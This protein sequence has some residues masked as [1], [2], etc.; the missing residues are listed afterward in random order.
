MEPELKALGQVAFRIA[1]AGND[2]W[3]DDVI[4]VDGIH[5]S[6]FE[7]VRNAL[8]RLRDGAPVGNLVIQGR[9]GIG[10]SH[11]LGRV[12][13][14]AVDRGQIF[15]LF[16]P[17]TARQFWDSLALAYG[18]ALH[19]EVDTDGTQLRTVLHG[20][21][22]AIGLQRAEIDDLVAGTFDLTRLKVVRRNLQMHLGRRPGHRVA[23]DVALALI[24]TNSEDLAHQDIGDALIQGLEIDAEEAR[25]HSIRA[26][27]IPC[28]EVV[29][30]FDKLIAAAGCT[31]LVAVDQLDG[32]LALGRSLDGA[33]EQSLLHEVANGLMD[34]AEDVQYSLIVLSCLNDSWAL[35]RDQA[36]PTAHARYSTI[37]ELQLI[38]SAE[39]GKALVAA[40]LREAYARAGF[41]PEYS[42]WPVRTTAFDDAILFSPRSLITVVQDHC[43]R[44]RENGCVTELTQLPNEIKGSEPLPRGQRLVGG[45]PPPPDPELDQRFSRLVQEANVAD[46]LD[47]K[48]VDYGLPPLLRAGL[49]AWTEENPAAGDFSVDPPLGRNPSLHA[50][51]R[52]IVDADSDDE[53]HSSFR[54]VLNANPVAALH[55][56]R[57]AVTASGLELSGERRRLFILRNAAWSQGLKTR[58]ALDELG[59]RGGT[60]MM[61]PQADLAVFRALQ[62]LLEEKPTGLA[63]WLRTHRHASRTALLAPLSPEPAVASAPTEA[64]APPKAAAA[65]GATAPPKAAVLTKAAEPANADT[66]PKV[67]EPAQ[68]AEPAK[69]VAPAK[70]AELPKTTAP[71]K[72]AAPSRAAV[73]SKAAA[74]SRAADEDSILIGTAE[75][76]GRHV[77]VPLED[78]RRHTVIFAGSGSGKTVLI[79]RLIEEC[80][81]KGV[82]AVVLDPN[83]DL[84]RLGL[85]WPEPPQSWLDGD[86]EKAATYLRDTEVVVWTPRLTTGRPLSFA[87]LAGLGDVADD[88][89]EFGIALDNAVASLVPRSGLPGSGARLSRGRAVLK[90]ALAAYVGSGGGDLRGFLGYLSAL[91]EGVSRLASAEKL[92][93]DI[94]QTLL[95]ETVNDPML[96]GTGEAVDPS[97]LLQPAGGRR[98]RISV[99]SL[100]GLPNDEQRQHFVNQLQMALFAWVKKHPAGDRPL[101]GLFVMDEA[102]TFA[103]SSGRTA[104]TDSTLALASQ[105]RKYGL[106]LVFATQA[107]KGLHNQIA[108]NATTQF[109]GLLNAPAQIAAAQEMAAQKGG[110][111]LG[112]ARLR[113]GEFFA[114]SDTVAFQRVRSPMCLSHHPR[115][116]MTQEEILELARAQ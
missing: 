74:A 103:P 6:A 76:T 66:P 62:Q 43:V 31:T 16:Q 29:G 69:P 47:E 72:T 61:L 111:A 110:D 87:P 20:L 17:S 86:A 57:A 53:V 39:V 63:A 14:A 25:A 108:G 102:Q 37:V 7:R 52:R 98:A 75:G 81:L 21:G 68:S 12:R 78:L 77:T 13:Q 85:P 65:G 26:S 35:I 11:F 106:G 100:V 115:S 42:T 114:A 71:S 51:L 9:P 109:F 54:A 84:A 1:Y 97:V 28:R 48:K 40:Y 73:P 41:T 105:A 112:I 2:I 92:A 101:G 80:A 55:R 89:D 15:V 45:D 99:I 44:C 104:T 95:A 33:E 27:R 79:R 116:P 60:V 113:P 58:Q 91:P 107:P 83:N 59:A 30:A 8:D 19:R 23:V 34:L 38:P 94:A 93:A 90:E 64:G 70:T 3:R 32:L 49:T 46:A 50:R 88:P 96:G 10:K 82:S 22:G 36:V 5:S 4:H 67:A 56:L 24:L 18:D